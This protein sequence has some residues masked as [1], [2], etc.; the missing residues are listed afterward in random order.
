LRSARRGITGRTSTRE[1]LMYIGVG[2]VLVVLVIIL[3]VMMIRGR[4]TI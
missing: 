2:T 4:R 1:L 3:L